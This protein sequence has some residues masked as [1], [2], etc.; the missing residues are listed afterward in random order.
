[1]PTFDVTLE[2]SERRIYIIEAP[3]ILSAE[4]EAIDAYDHGEMGDSEAV[5]DVWVRK[6]V[7]VGC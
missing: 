1:M 2:T 4:A 6:V 3:D 5:L 7:E